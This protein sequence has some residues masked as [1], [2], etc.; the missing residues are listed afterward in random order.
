MMAFGKKPD[1][2]LEMYKRDGP[3]IFTGQSLKCQV[4][5]PLGLRYAYYPDNKPLADCMDADRDL[6]GKKF[7]D[8]PNGKKLM[9]TAFDCDGE[10]KEELGHTR[11]WHSKYFHNFNN[12]DKEMELKDACLASTACPC[13]W[14]LHKGYCDGGVFANHPVTSALSI[15]C[16]DSLGNQNLE[17]CVLLN[18]GCGENRHAKM[19]VEQDEN[20]GVVSW[21]LPLINIMFEGQ[22]TTACFEGDAFLGSRFC[23]LSP[24]VENEDT[25]DTWSASP[26]N[27]K[28]MIDL[29]NNKDFAKNLDRGNL[30]VKEHFMPPSSKKPKPQ[31]IDV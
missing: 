5:N 17:D 9:I 26:E 4:M 28:Y 1:D 24:D 2:C 6:A 20:M 29:V 12:E 14:P 21:I 10:H 7:G 3:K 23:R 30:F 8:V 15:A 18:I 22:K 31:E 27:I 19:H 13:M 25:P 11:G 16:K